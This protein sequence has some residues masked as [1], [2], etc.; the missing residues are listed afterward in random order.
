ME[1]SV[2]SLLLLA[3]AGIA[4]SANAPPPPPS[5]GVTQAP[6]P[7]A[8]F[9]ELKGQRQQLGNNAQDR[10]LP[11]RPTPG[12][13]RPD[14]SRWDLPVGYNA[15]NLGSLEDPTLLKDVVYDVNVGPKGLTAVKDEDLQ[16]CFIDHYIVPFVVP[17]QERRFYTHTLPG[18]LVDTPK[19][20]Y[21]YKSLVGRPI[22][23]MC[24]HLRTYWLDNGL[25]YKFNQLLADSSPSGSG[26]NSPSFMAGYMSKQGDDDIRR[27][28]PV[29]LY[30][31]LQQQG[32]ERSEASAPAPAL[33][34]APPP[35]AAYQ[36]LHPQ[37]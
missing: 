2:A 34:L 5:L 29:S 20:R 18:M 8:E 12:M 32:R 19:D 36:R 3:L 33:H 25:M 23:D 7:V 9:L 13:A 30:H 11:M 26:N 27:P 31:V 6:P 35:V 4:T 22:Y 14:E 24:H 10:N 21:V 28:P 1:F 17:H 37:P 16:A 15:Q